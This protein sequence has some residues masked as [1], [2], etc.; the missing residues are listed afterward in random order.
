[1]KGNI[2]LSVCLAL[3]SI[4][5]ANAQDGIVARHHSGKVTLYSG[6]KIQ[7]AMDASLKGDTLYLSEGL[8]AGFNL[9]HSIVL[10]GSGKNTIITGDVNFGDYYSP[11]GELDD[12][13][14]KGLN[15]LKAFMVWGRTKGF[16]MDQCI[17]E[18]LGI[19]S[20]MENA[21]ISRCFIKDLLQM[22]GGDVQGLTVRNSKIRIVY[23]GGSFPHAASFYNCNVGGSSDVRL[24]N[25]TYYQCIVGQTWY[26]TYV[27]CLYYQ[28]Y[29][30]ATITDSWRTTWDSSWSDY[31]EDGLNSPFSDEEMAG[32]GWLGADG[33]VVGI[34]G[35]DTPYTLELSTPH[36]VN[37]NVEVDNNNK[38]LKVSLKMN[39]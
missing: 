26:G 1:M 33:K 25:N 19:W 4:M 12:C 10:I 31:S 23:G 3:A 9:G 17:L 15:V 27:N 14:F 35:G 28:I 38:T 39:E 5:V 6:A 7:E 34:T 11:E 37:H 30:E 2:V 13:V 21:Q 20:T 36:V 22:N 18:R 24:E 32:Q 16:R 8:F 29:G